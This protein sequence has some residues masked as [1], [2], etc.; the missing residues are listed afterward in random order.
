LPFSRI[1]SSPDLEKAGE[2]DL[3]IDKPIEYEEM[4]DPGE[5]RK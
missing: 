4:S 5:I 2:K 3:E 1:C